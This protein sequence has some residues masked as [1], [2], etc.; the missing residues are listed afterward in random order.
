MDS[1]KK[2]LAD[3]NDQNKTLIANLKNAPGLPVLQSSAI[4]VLELCDRPDATTKQFVEVIEQDVGLSSMFLV[5][6]N[7]AAFMQS[8]PK[9]TI[10]QCLI[11]LGLRNTKEIALTFSLAKA[12]S[13]QAL[14]IEH[15]KRLVIRASLYQILTRGRHSQTILNPMLFDCGALA[16][17]A[18]GD[19]QLLRTLRI[20]DKRSAAGADRPCGC[21]PI[22][23]YQP[24]SRKKSKPV[25]NGYCPQVT[26]IPQT[27]W[28]VLC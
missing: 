23:A 4:K 16:V 26:G 7:S 2:F 18:L 21:F 12:G 14:S 1:S 25:M 28:G 24:R 19:D 13:A 10:E 20:L 22:G 5:A 17:A 27:P 6:A 8:Q 11:A 9:T 15:W 3:W